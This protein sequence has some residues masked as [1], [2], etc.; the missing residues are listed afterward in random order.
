MTIL[1][2][3]QYRGWKLRPH[4]LSYLDR[5]LTSTHIIIIFLYNVKQRKMDVMAISFLKKSGDIHTCQE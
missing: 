1:L 4:I 3:F 2:F 5:T